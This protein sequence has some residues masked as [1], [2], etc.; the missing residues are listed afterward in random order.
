MRSA[1][2]DHRGQPDVI[3]LRIQPHGHHVHRTRCPRQPPRSGDRTG[4]DY[5]AAVLAQRLGDAYITTLEIDPALCQR[6]RQALASLAYYPQVMCADGAAG[7]DMDK[8]YDRVI[9]IVALPR[10]PPH[11]WIRPAPA[12]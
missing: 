4:T 3:Q 5:N 9:S 8:P 10:I 1:W 7:I 11:G 6:A 2:R 12:R